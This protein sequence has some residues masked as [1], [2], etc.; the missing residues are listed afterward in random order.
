MGEGRRR[1][2]GEGLGVG[3]WGLEGVGV[4]RW[5]GTLEGWGG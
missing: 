2:I 5:L 3:G 1:R 4:V